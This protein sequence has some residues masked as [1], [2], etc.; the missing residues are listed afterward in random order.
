M[1]AVEEVYVRVSKLSSL[2]WRQKARLVKTFFLKKKK[3]TT[4]NKKTKN[5]QTV[6]CFKM[7]SAE[8]FTQSAKR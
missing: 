5:K 3:K 6:K 2:D 4:K 7:S 1:H 8:K